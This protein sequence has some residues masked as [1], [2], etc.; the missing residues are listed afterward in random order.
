MYGVCVL[1]FRIRCRNGRVVNIARFP[2]PPSTVSVE[3]ALPANK[4]D[5]RENPPVRRRFEYANKTLGTL[6]SSHRR[7]RWPYKGPAILGNRVRNR[8]TSTPLP[9]FGLGTIRPTELINALYF[10]IIVRRH[11]C[12]VKK[13]LHT[14]SPWHGDVGELDFFRFLRRSFPTGRR[15]VVGTAQN[16]LTA[17]THVRQS[18]VYYYYY[19][20]I[21]PLN[22][23]VHRRDKTRTSPFQ[24]CRRVRETLDF[25]RFRM[26]PRF[27]LHRHC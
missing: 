25:P 19:L 13:I 5:N 14:P 21:A 7:K 18:N 15:D 1:L 16:V 2:P 22:A 10:I 6:R 24:P 9:F 3:S 20:C 26:V 4:T 12:S 23:N 27:A 8:S 17:C 11:L